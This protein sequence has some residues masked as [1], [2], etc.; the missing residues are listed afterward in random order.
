MEV[1]ILFWQ[2]DR[3]KNR[4]RTHARYARVMRN[5]VN[6][7]VDFN[8]KNKNKCTKIDKANCTKV[9]P[10]K[11]FGYNVHVLSFLNDVGY[12]IIDTRVPC[13][14]NTSCIYTEFTHGQTIRIVNQGK[15]VRYEK[16]SEIKS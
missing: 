14:V 8:V 7:H 10:L 1:K 13:L 16:S 11:N 3:P 6:H 5:T 4:N 15:L 12:R 2:T 9:S